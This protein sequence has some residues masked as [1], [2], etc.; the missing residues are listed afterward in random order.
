MKNYTKSTFTHFRRDQ[1]QYCIKYDRH[2]T[3]NRLL[4]LIIYFPHIQTLSD[5]GQGERRRAARRAGVDAEVDSD[6][7]ARRVAQP[8]ATVP[9]TS[10]TLRLRRTYI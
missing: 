1:R 3:T 10:P 8:H 4:L 9:E 7:V 5:P 2:D 6:R